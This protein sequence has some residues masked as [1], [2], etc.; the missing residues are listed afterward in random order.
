MTTRTHEALQIRQ[1]TEKDVDSLA[2]FA[3]RT[4]IDTYDDLTRQEAEAYI[5][6]FLSPSVFEAHIKSSTSA[7]FVAEKCA[8]AGYVL[9]EV[10]RSPI[11]LGLDNHI[12]CV[13]LFVD[14]DLKGLR[15]GSNLLDRAIS[16]SIRT[17]SDVMWLKVW[18]QNTRAIEFYE[19]KGFRVQGS[20]E[21]TE[22][23]MD[24]EVLIMALFLGDSPMGQL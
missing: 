10:S 23:G 22:G 18:D 5:G 2:S 1:A 9:M 24:D 6:E 12:E 7:V 21:Y 4:F 19:R 13:R 14:T 16:Y 17:K 3:A 11:S 20:V 8:L 15:I